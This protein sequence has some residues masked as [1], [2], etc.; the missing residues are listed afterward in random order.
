MV[1]QYG[2]FLLRWWRR[3]SGTQRIEVEHIQSDAKTVV[4]SAPAAL[5]WVTARFEGADARGTPPK[6]ERRSESHG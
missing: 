1:K 5:E 6:S 4:S 2:S 3:D